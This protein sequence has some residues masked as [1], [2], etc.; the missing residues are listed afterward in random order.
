MP[1]VECKVGADGTVERAKLHNL[2][3][4]DDRVHSKR[5]SMEYISLLNTV[6]KSEEKN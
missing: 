5:V 2:P 1:K 4:F 6:I 3:G